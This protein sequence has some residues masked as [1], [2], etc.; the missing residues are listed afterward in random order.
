M[1]GAVLLK[2][3]KLILRCSYA[4]QQKRSIWKQSRTFPWKLFLDRL[5][6]RRSIPMNIRSY[7]GT[8]YVGAAQTLKNLFKEPAVQYPLHARIP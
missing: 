3:F 7:C 5:V 2:M 4:Y 8:N 6:A 1:P